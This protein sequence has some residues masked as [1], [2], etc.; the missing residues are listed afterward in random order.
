MKTQLF[1]LISFYSPEWFLT[2]KYNGEPYTVWALGILLYVMVRGNFPFHTKEEICNE[3]VD[4]DFNIKPK[5]QDIIRRCLQKCPEDRPSLVELL[6]DPFFM[7]TGSSLG[8]S[9]DSS[10]NSSLVSSLGNACQNPTEESVEKNSLD[11]SLDSALGS[12]LDGSLDSSLG[13]SL[14]SSLDS[15]L[16]SSLSSSL[17]SSLDRSL[18]S[19]LGNACQNPKE[20]PV[21]KNDKH[22]G[23]KRKC[24]N[25]PIQ[26]DPNFDAKRKKLEARFLK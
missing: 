5:T 19:S 21:E 11:S 23:E 7:N 2:Q 4:I 26:A 24:Q 16:D 15:S 18:D 22:P 14:N 20:E 10:L 9:L 8:S 13:S 1:K 17:D 12:S 25:T 3:H 6:S